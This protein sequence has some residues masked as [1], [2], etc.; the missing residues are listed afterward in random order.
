MLCW[1]GLHFAAFV[2]NAHSPYSHLLVAHALASL[3]LF[4]TS[5]RALGPPVVWSSGLGVTALLPFV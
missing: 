3:T 2:S 5:L 1:G 4:L